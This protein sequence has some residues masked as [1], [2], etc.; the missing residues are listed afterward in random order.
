MN[1]DDTGRLILDK[2]SVKLNPYIPRSNKIYELA[3]D[4]EIL[5]GSGGTLIVDTECYTNYFLIAFK[6]IQTKKIIKFEASNTDLFNSKK[7]SWIM[8]Q[9]TTIGFNSIKYD[10]AM[11]W[12]SYYNQSPIFLKEVS[13][14]L[15]FQNIFWREIQK[16]FNFS[17]RTK[18]FLLGKKSRTK[19][20]DSFVAR[21]SRQ[22]RRLD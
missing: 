6:D 15:I 21:V 1:I 13:D 14:T 4:Q 10:L 7:L 3:T 19:K 11:I 18:N 8:H 20:S 17:R 5:N 12:C 22:P 2:L 16:K 9:Y